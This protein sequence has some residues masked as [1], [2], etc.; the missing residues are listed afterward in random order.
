LLTV[1]IWGG[2]LWLWQNGQDGLS[3]AAPEPIDIAVNP[4]TFATPTVTATATL[5]A[6]PT[7]TPMPTDAPSP[8]ATPTPTLTPTAPPPPSLTPT[9]VETTT[10]E[11]DDI[12][13]TSDPLAELAQIVT[14]AN[15]LLV[16]YLE[17]GDEVSDEA[18]ATLWQGAALA[19]TRAFAE[20]TRLRYQAPL[21]VTF[22]TVETPTVT[23]IDP[24][25]LSVQTRE[26]WTY[27]GAQARREALGEYNYT[28]QLA[29]G[30]WK[31]VGYTFRAL[32]V[33]AELSTITNTTVLT[34]ADTAP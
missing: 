18:L 31:I 14:D 33:P 19:D 25:T 16:V 13:P 8:E 3:P 6:L 5:T 20:Q 23:A 26:F 11:A 22:T 24:T 1:V 30:D 4:A 10:I 29:D 32:P 9:V 2:G 7:S 28:L 21:T 12:V 34:S 17:T 27:E 15:D